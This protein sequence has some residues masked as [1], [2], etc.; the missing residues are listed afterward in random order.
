MLNPTVIY[1]SGTLYK[2][3][4]INLLEQ[5][6]SHPFTYYRSVQGNNQYSENWLKTFI[7]KSLK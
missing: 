2:Y 1:E 5:F 4:R 3:L 7:M 6:I